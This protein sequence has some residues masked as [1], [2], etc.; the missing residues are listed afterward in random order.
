MAPRQP[1]SVLCPPGSETG[2]E[3]H[4]HPSAPLEH[5]GDGEHALTSSATVTLTDLSLSNEENSWSTQPVIV[6]DKSESLLYICEVRYKMAERG[7][8]TAL[9]KRGRARRSLR[10]SGL[11]HDVVYRQQTH[12]GLTP[13]TNPNIPV[14]M[15]DDQ[16]EALRRD[17]CE[18]L[19]VMRSKS[20][21]RM[22]AD[23][24]KLIGDAL[25]K[26]P[27]LQ[28]PDAYPKAA[29]TLPS[30]TSETFTLERAAPVVTGRGWVPWP[31]ST[32]LL[33][34]HCCHAF[35]TT[36]VPGVCAS[37]DKRA[38]VKVCGV[39]CT[40][41]CSKAW[42]LRQG[43]HRHVSTL[44]QIYRAAGGQ[45]TTIQPA[46]PREAL[47][48]FGGNIG[49]DEFRS[50]L[51]RLCWVPVDLPFK[52]QLKQMSYWGMGRKPAQQQSRQTH[53]THQTQQQTQHQTQQT[54]QVQQQ[55]VQRHQAARQSVSA[56]PPRPNTSLCQGLLEQKPR[57]DGTTLDKFITMP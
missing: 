53:Q 34:W 6:T 29:C 7:N 54:Q 40:W 32:D 30:R 12:L 15:I 25:G 18:R 48:A 44:R 37:D 16:G 26:A 1:T 23:A 50:G 56:E 41:S 19:A 13:G 49:I 57:H 14:C 42:M 35:D 24:Q 31:E 17:L 20:G 52:I 36:P 21:I 45:D 8:N 5:V 33:C 28:Q 51:Q 2:R 27:T 46:P 9:G 22:A 47:C 39:F 10:G 3:P 11:A 38:I 43:L 55:Q 4:A